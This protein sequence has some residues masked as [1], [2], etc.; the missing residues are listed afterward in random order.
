MQAW[1]MLHKFSNYKFFENCCKR[2]ETTCPGWLY[3]LVL[4]TLLTFYLSSWFRSI[5][6]WNRLASAIAS[7][8]LFEATPVS[9]KTAQLPLLPF[10]EHADET[11]SLW[12]PVSKCQNQSRPRWFAGRELLWEDV[13][14]LSSLLVKCCFYTVG[15]FCTSRNTTTYHMYHFW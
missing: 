14:D 2:V 3:Q 15:L 12:N 5:Q 4:C 11:L 1:G 10:V 13:L 9:I 7:R 6:E 8:G